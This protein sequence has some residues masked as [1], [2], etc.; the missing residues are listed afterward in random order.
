MVD[1]IAQILARRFG[2]KA[3]LYGKFH[4][5]ELVRADLALYLPGLYEKDADLV[6]V[7]FD[8]DYEHKPWCGLEWRAIYSLIMPRNV[9]DV[10][11]M[12]W[13]FSDPQGLYGFG[14]I[15]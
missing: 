3:I 12:R 9:Q 8:D 5:P 15:H 11:L 14:W 4:Q 6:A 2:E 10:M 13:N 1:E 7:V